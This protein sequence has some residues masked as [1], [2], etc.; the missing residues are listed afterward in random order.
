MEMKNENLKKHT[1][2]T[3][4]TGIVTSRAERGVG[5]DKQEGRS[6]RKKEEC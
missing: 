2:P 3:I 1:L 4:Y 6:N 5:S